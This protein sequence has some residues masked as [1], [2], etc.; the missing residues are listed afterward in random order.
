M[1]SEGKGQIAFYFFLLVC[2]IL[3]LYLV[4]NYF[5]DNV[6]IAV[7]LSCIVGS[8]FLIFYERRN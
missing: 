8:A 2:S 7:C 4:W 3:A 1:G 6:A 5:Y